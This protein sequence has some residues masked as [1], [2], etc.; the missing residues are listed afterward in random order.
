MDI[1]AGGNYEQS[2]GAGMMAWGRMYQGG[3]QPNARVLF[4]HNTLRCSGGLRATSDDEAT[5]LPPVP[6]LGPYNSGLAFRRNTLLAG[7]GVSL[8]GATWDVVTDQNIFAPSPCRAGGAVL[9]AGTTVVANTTQ[10][11]LVRA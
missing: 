8:A 11:V 5:P 9:P 6:F 7:S 3:W 2:V 4:E 1:T 10:H